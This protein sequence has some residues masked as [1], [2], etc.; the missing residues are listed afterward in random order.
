MEKKK[1]TRY[2]AIA[3]IATFIAVHIAFGTEQIGYNT[4][5]PWWT[6]ITYIFAH[7]NIYHL[8]GNAIA[9]YTCFGTYATFHLI[10]PRSALLLCTG[11]A[12]AASFFAEYERPTVGASGA[13]YALFGMI[14]ARLLCSH[15][16]Y[17]MTRNLGA[18][19]VTLAACLLMQAFSA[20]V[21]VRL[22]LICLFL[23]FVV[24]NLAVIRKNVVPFA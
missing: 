20:G 4:T 5:S 13:I 17:T 19:F 9:F 23:G 8:V 6:H 14:V 11:I 3:V 7:V 2:T 12:F 15:T 1:E 22:H 16:I 21:N 24:G 18:F 10:K